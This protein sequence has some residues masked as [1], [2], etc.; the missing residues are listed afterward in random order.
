MNMTLIIAA[1]GVIAV[2]LLIM[3]IGSLMQ[4]GS[5]KAERRVRNRLKALALS[6]A[7]DATIDLVLRESSMSDVPFF[8]RLLESVRWTSRLNLLMY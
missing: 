3:G 8:N 2:F 1:V 6:G 4:S 7:D 5:D